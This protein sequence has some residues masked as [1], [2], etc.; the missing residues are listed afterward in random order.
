[1]FEIRFLFSNTVF[2][3]SGYCS[4]TSLSHTIVQFLRFGEEL[5]GVSHTAKTVTLQS[6]TITTT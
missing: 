3:A 5:V 2:K 6:A 1:M 4:L